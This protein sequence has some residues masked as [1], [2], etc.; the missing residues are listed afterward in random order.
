[1][2]DTGHGA[3]GCDAMRL[4][5]PLQGREVVGVQQGDVRGPGLDDPAVARQPEVRDLHVHDPCGGD[6]SQV[7]L[8]AGGLV[9]QRARGVVG[10]V[11]RH[12]HLEAQS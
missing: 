5:E 2:H 6:V 7:S 11:E 1:M 3:R 12:D 9:H 8:R 10:V 4:G